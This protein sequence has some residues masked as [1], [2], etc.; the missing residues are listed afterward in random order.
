[1]NATR[2]KPARTL[3]ILNAVTGRLLV[4]RV[5]EGKRVDDYT[6][7]SR[8]GAVWIDHTADRDRKYRVD[9]TSGKPAVCDCPANPRVAVCRHIAMSKKLVADGYLALPEV[10]ADDRETVADLAADAEGRDAYYTAR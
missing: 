7:S 8:D 5:K 9:C 10:D 1:M 2:P 3:D 6:V 4:V